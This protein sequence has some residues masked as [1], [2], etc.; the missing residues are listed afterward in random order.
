M[1]E[2]RDGPGEGEPVEGAAFGDGV[3]AAVETENPNS[4]NWWWN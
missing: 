4:V 2:F 3:A 1:Q